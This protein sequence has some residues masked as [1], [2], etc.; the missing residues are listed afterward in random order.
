VRRACD[1]TGLGPRTIKCPESLYGREKSL[2]TGLYNLHKPESNETRE[3]CLKIQN[4]GKTLILGPNLSFDSNEDPVDKLK[5][6]ALFLT[7]VLY[8]N[9]QSVFADLYG[10]HNHC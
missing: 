5:R 3:S 10:L 4:S 6:L 9:E 7:D 8:R 1:L 2:F